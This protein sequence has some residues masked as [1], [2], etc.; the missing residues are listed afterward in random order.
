MKVFKIGLIADCLRLPFRESIEKSAQLGAEGVQL[1]AVNGEMAP[2]NMTRQ[3]I[4]EKRSILDA[5][6]LKVSAL[7]GDLGGHGFTIEEDNQWKIERS[8]K[9]VDLALELGSNIVTTHIGVVPRDKTSRTYK[10][11]QEACN[12]LAEYAHSQGAYFAIET[13]PETATSLKDFL[14]SLSSKGVAV[15]MDPANLVMVTGD[16]P[17]KA[18]YTLRDYIVHTH[19]KDGI[20]LKQTDPKLIYDFFAEGGIGDLRLDEYFKEVP[21]GQGQVDFKAYLAALR[22]IG[23]SGYLTIERETGPD[24]LE[25]IRQAISYLRAI[26]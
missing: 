23:F 1:Y 18:V 8:K 12:E 5:N 6:G 4:V 15:N 24:P 19:A 22:D 3:D 11:L 2:E 16:D 10:V 14:D 7:C 9:I 13:G 17:V 26:I 21:L 25:D 20:M